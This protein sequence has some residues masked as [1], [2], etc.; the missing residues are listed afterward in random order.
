MDERRT[1]ETRTDF[2]VRPTSRRKQ[3][4]RSCPF[5]AI[6]AAFPQFFL[7]NICYCIIK[8]TAFKSCSYYQRETKAAMVFYNRSVNHTLLRFF[9]FWQ[10]N[11]VFFA[12][13]CFSSF[14]LLFFAGDV[15]DHPALTHRSLPDPVERHCT[16]RNNLIEFFWA[17][18]MVVGK[19]KIL[20]PVS[21][22]V[23]PP[24]PGRP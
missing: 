4:L 23:A 2:F 10:S 22:P 9:L 21:S 14:L 19:E 15:L 17:T 13:L 20:H 18:S 3:N 5:P 8:L 7:F 24:V 12:P 1:E 11:P 6:S 16:E